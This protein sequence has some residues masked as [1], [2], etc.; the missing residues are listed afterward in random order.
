MTFTAKKS[1]GQHFLLNPSLLEKIVRVA[2]IGPDDFVLEIGPGPG[3]LTIYLAAKAKRVVTVEKD[4]RFAQKLR[5]DFKN[6]SKISIVEADFLNVDLKNILKAHPQW[7]VVANLPYNVATVILFQLLEER[8]F[9][10]DLHLMVQREVAERLVAKPGSKDFGILS[11]MGQ[12]YS[13]NKISMRLPPGAF[14]PPPK[15]HSAVVSFRI[16]KDCRFPIHDLKFFKKLVTAAFGQRRKMLRNAIREVQPG[17]S[18]E[19][20]KKILEEAGILPD[21]RAEIVSIQHFAKL[22]NALS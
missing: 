16:Q 13:E 7:K 19:G 14:H 4:W 12:L 5:D 18:P 6:D 10:S 11:I 15:V 8:S 20:L 22:A 21:A 3:G 1:L 9:F 17:V 2:G